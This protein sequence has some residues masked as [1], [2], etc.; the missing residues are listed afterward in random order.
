VTRAVL[1]AED[2][3]NIVI[4]LE[5]LLKRGG[6]IVRTAPDGPAAL[7]SIEENP[8]DLLLLDIMLPGC[9]GFAVAAAVRRRS[10]LR[11]MRIVMLTAKG[12]EADRSRGLQVGIDDYITKPFSTRDVM[13]RVRALLAA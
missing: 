3:P 2:E 10:E 12:G 4:S 6:F 11:D 5:F 9:D 1:I 13:A 8:P 7:R